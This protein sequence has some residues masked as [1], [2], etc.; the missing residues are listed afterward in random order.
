MCDRLIK[1]IEEVCAPFKKEE[2]K[3][4]EEDLLTSQHLSRQVIECA[5][6][7]FPGEERNKTLG[8]LM[9]VSD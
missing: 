6:K 2:H 5:L 4:E 9:L 3:D 1:E 7:K 8:E